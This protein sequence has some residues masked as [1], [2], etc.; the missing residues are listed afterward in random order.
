MRGVFHAGASYHPSISADGRYVVFVSEET[1]SP[2]SFGQSVAHIYLHDR[3]SARTDLVSRQSDGRAADGSSRYPEIA[4][5]ASVIAFQSLA[6]NLACAKRCPR[7]ARDINLVWDVFV[8]FID[9][10]AI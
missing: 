7:D 2:G 1:N 5:D 4:G 8:F 10:A 3:T 9:E 6:S